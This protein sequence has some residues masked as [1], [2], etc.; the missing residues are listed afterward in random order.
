MQRCT[1]ND[2]MTHPEDMIE[3]LGMKGWYSKHETLWSSAS[4]NKATQTIK[5]SIISPIHS[6]IVKTAVKV[7]SKK[8]C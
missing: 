8:K 6:I 1:S 4:S 5:Y 3:S 2:H 7:S